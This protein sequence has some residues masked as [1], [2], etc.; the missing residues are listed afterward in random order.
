MHKYK[1]SVLASLMVVS[2]LAIQTAHARGLS[3]TRM[4]QQGWFC[5]TAGPNNWVHC[6]NP[7]AAFDEKALNVMVFD[8]T[9]PGADG[10]FLGTELL[11][12]ET[13]FAEQPCPQD[14]G[15]YEAL[16]G[17][18]YYACHHYDTSH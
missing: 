13:V 9:D 2:L 17:L 16:A 7:A 10:P 18:P 4:M 5:F 12:H 6:I 11:I 8:S 3:N 1:F 14:S 15:E